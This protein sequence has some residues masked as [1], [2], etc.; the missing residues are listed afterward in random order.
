MR[1]RPLYQLFQPCGGSRNELQRS[2]P[3]DGEWCSAEYTMLCFLMTATPPFMVL[4]IHAIA[5]SASL[6][7]ETGA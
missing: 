3:L 2:S 1:E 7:S 4:R 5:Y 6:I